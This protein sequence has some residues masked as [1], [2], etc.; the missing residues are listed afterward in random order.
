MGMS[1]E[2][3]PRP[4]AVREHGLTYNDYAAIDDG[5]RYELA[6]GKLELMSPAPSV[7]HQLVSFEIQRTVFDSCGSQFIILNAPVDLILSQS[8]V[9]Q[10]DLVIIRRD[11]IHII[12]RRGIEG[13]PDVVVEI[14]SPS[15]LKRDR[16]D[17][18]K[19]YARFEIPEYWVIDPEMGS[20]EQYLL[21][22]KRYELNY[23]YVGDDP[24][25]SPGMPCASFTMK[26]I[27]NNVPNIPK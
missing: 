26:G 8:E 3:K 17:K 5:N 16:L 27:M 20:L 25:T 22:G 23:V 2:R 6:G 18:L 19:T 9:R 4:E 11:R 1:N 13:P 24:V 15:T 14:L 10:P 7:G 12:T 21:E